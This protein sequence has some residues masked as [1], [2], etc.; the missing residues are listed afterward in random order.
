VGFRG[1][2]EV[3]LGRGAVGARGSYE[4][5]DDGWSRS[6]LTVGATVFF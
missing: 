3:R 2:A 4:R 5:G 1:E 6:E